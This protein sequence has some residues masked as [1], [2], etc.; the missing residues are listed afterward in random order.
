MWC[1][2]VRKKVTIG[3]WKLGNWK[4]LIRARSTN[5][6]KRPNI[7]QTFGIAISISYMPS[8]GFGGKILWKIVNRLLVVFRLISEKYIFLEFLP[9]GKAH[10]RKLSKVTYKCIKFCENWNA[11]LNKK[12]KV[13]YLNNLQL[14]YLKGC[15]SFQKRF[16]AKSKKGLERHI[17]V[18]KLLELKGGDF[19]N[20]RTKINKFK[21]NHPDFIVRRAD[22]GDYSALL[23]LKQLWNEKSGIKYPSIWDHYFYKNLIR[24]YKD[25]GHIL[26]VVEIKGRIVGMTW[27]D[28][29]KWPRLG[30]VN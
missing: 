30:P 10:P 15:S 28:C 26:L 17:G 16:I 24:N 14:D 2:Y 18:Q 12:G 9:F 23:E 6:L 20:I 4:W 22:D 25:L 5:S 3:N 27:G 21:K 11:K 1:K 7:L 13:K 8:S 19:Q 29:F